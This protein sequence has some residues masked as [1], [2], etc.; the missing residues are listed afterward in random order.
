MTESKIRKWIYDKKDDIVRDLIHLVNIESIS[1]PEDEIYPFGQ[2]CRDVLDEYSQ[3]SEEM[4]L[5]ARNFDYACVGV[6]I[7]EDDTK[8]PN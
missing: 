7:S 3:M 2:K 6:G 4:G 8:N 1:N 5:Y